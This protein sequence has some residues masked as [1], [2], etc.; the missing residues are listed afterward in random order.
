[1]VIIHSLQYIFS[2]SQHTDQEM[3]LL[4]KKKKHLLDKANSAPISPKSATKKESQ[5]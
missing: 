5:N 3:Q 1:M 4:A 2:Y